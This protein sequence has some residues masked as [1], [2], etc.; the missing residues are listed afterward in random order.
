M[1]SSSLLCYNY[2]TNS[3]TSLSSLPNKLPHRCSAISAASSINSINKYSSLNP[4]PVV[5]EDDSFKDGDMVSSAASVASAIRKASN[6]PVEFM[7]RS[8]RKGS[9][10]GG[11]EIMLPSSDFIR[12]CVQQLDL[13]RRI[14]HPDA[15]LSVSFL[16]FRGS[17]FGFGD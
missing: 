5:N 1:A 16:A 14:V 9:K 7:H 3:H 4:K 2:L 6:S 10:G 17:V 8:Q 12:L 13:F 15:I 11:V